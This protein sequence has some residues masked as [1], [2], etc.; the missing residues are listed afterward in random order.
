V[1]TLT[2]RIFLRLLF[3][4]RVPQPVKLHFS[5]KKANFLIVTTLVAVVCR[6]ERLMQITHEMDNKFER[7]QFFFRTGRRISESL[8]CLI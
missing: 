8:L 6:M 4:E 1:K 2:P 5:L 3:D 7:S